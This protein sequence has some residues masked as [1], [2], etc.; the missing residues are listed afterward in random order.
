LD[1]QIRSQL[2]IK[3]ADQKALESGFAGF[4]FRKNEIQTVLEIEQ[5]IP[6]LPEPEDMAAQKNHRSLTSRPLSA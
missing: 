1:S 3:Q 6:K 4:I 2:S 5:K